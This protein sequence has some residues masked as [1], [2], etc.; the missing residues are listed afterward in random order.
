MSGRSDAPATLNELEA[1]LR[2]PDAVLEP[3]IVE[4]LKQ[5]V[6]C[7]GQPQQAVEYLTDGYQGDLR[8]G[9]VLSW[10]RQ[11]RAGVRGW[12]CLAGRTPRLLL[13]F[14][15]LAVLDAGYAQMAVLMC[16]WLAS[17]ATP[18]EER[19]PE[20]PPAPPMDEA[21]LLR[22]STAR[23]EVACVCNVCAS[24]PGPGGMC[25]GGNGCQ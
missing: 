20:Q 1:F 18:G 11:G 21:C 5:Y 16:Q 6:M 17:T 25:A 14:D 8:R 19:S 3:T 15:A 9:L 22:V 12:Q 4:R 13:F 23:R 24:G 7:Q 2:Q 10:G